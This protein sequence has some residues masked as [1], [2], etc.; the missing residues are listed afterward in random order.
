MDFDDGHERETVTEQPESQMPTFA[1]L[2]NALMAGYAATAQ[3][4][5]LDRVVG[6]YGVV[7]RDGADRLWQWALSHG[8]W[9]AE[10]H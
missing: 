8:I 7:T 1:M 9:Q 3:H 6:E 10:K 5:R 4:T 2:R